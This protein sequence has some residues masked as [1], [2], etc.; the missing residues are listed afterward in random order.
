MMRLSFAFVFL[1]IVATNPRFRGVE[2]LGPDMFPKE[3]RAGKGYVHQHPDIAGRPVMVAIARRH[4][5]LVTIFWFSHWWTHPDWGNLLGSTGNMFCHFVFTPGANP[6][7]FW[8]G[9]V[10]KFAD[11]LLDVGNRPEKVGRARTPLT[12]GCRIPR[13][14]ART[15]AGYFWPPGVFTLASRSG[16]GRF[17]DWSVVQLLPCAHWQGASGGCPRPF[18]GLLGQHQ[19]AAGEVFQIGGL[20]HSRRASGKLFQ[21][22]LGATGVSQ[23]GACCHAIHVNH[24]IHAQHDGRVDLHGLRGWQPGGLENLE[25]SATAPWPFGPSCI[26][27][28][29]WELADFCDDRGG[30]AQCWGGHWRVTKENSGSLKVARKAS[31]RESWLALVV[32]EGSKDGCGRSSQQAG[33]VP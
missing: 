16:S 32:F 23:I 33:E 12:W 4:S 13:R 19:T 10:G 15:S 7:H 22:R 27:G 31:G 18:Q 21:A 5:I 6:R 1:F 25:A 8:P 28:W 24:A 20:C 3:L 11:V 2:Y 30:C 17:F 14:D 26:S 29:G 9:L